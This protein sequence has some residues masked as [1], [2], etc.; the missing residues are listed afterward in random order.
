[1]E[2]DVRTWL[3]LHCLGGWEGGGAWEGSYPGSFIMYVGCYCFRRGTVG[4]GCMYST[5]VGRWVGE[6]VG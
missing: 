2:E 5:Y 1:M 3:C 4:T 6:L